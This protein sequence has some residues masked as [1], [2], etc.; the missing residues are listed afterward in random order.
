MTLDNG[1]FLTAGGMIIAAIV[2]LV[3]LEGRINVTAS[4]FTE[5]IRRLERIEHRQDHELP[6]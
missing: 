6:G 4:Q 5:I 1:S 2:W 3:R